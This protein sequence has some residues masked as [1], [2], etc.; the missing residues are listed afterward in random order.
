[1]NAQFPGAINAQRLAYILIF[2]R[3]KIGSGK[4]SPIST[5]NGAFIKKSATFH[6]EAELEYNQ[7]AGVDEAGYGA[8]AGPVAVCAVM[9]NVESFP[10]ELKKVVYDSKYLNAKTR[11]YIHDT[12]IANPRYGTFS[13]EMVWPEEIHYH[14]VLRATLYGM[15]RALMNLKPRPYH[16]LIDG[17]R[18]I[19][20]LT[21]EITQHPLIKGDQKSYSIAMA[22]IIAKVKR[23]T[24]MDTLHTH[25]QYYGWNTNKGYGTL[26]HTEA[27]KVFGSCLHHRKGYK[28]KALKNI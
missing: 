10:E 20:F 12:F 6:F 14:N 18:S 15:E 4:L 9:L 1:M 27:L 2:L 21:K 3:S 13:I 16:V 5:K 22:S 23:D 26:K 8:W 25:H 28:I 17:P 24:L 11:T 7:V 19:P